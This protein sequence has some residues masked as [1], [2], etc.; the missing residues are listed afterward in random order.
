MDE[1]ED[2][3]PLLPESCVDRE[4]AFNKST[5]LFRVRAVAGLPIDDAVPNGALGEVVGG[6]D[7]IDVDEGPKRIGMFE[8]V[9]ARFSG[10]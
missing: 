4:N 1:V 9:R 2:V 6:L 3:A 7:A 10:F 5:T 8:Q